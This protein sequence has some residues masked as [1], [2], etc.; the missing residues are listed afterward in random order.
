M[1]TYLALIKNDLRLALRGRSVVFFNYLFP[2]M[3]FF[4]FAEFMGGGGSAGMAQ[5]VTMVLVIGIMGNGLW[6]AGMRLVQEREMNI[7]RRFRVTPISPLPI[8]VA[9]MVT[10]WPPSGSSL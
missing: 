7:L 8:L 1:K 3:F 4:A 9:S 2:L 6:G 10:G 5:V